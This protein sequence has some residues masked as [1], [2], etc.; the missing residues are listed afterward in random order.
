MKATV[1]MTTVKS[2]LEISG[3]LS[4]H[5]VG[6]GFPVRTLLS[7]Q[8]QGQGSS[9]FLLLDYA[10]PREFA[11]TGDRRGV[12]EHPH[13]GFETVTI[14]YQ[15]ELE[16]RDSAGHHGRLGPGDVQWMTAASG[17]VHEEMHE[18]EFARRGGVFEVVQL[19][20][21]LPAAQKLSPPRYQEIT[22]SRIPV[23]TLPGGAYARVIAGECG[24]IAGAARTVTPLNVWDVRVA[25]GRRADLK[26]PAGHNAMVALL[27]GEVTLDGQERL[28]GPQIVQLGRDGDR[29]V[30]EAQ[31][32]AGLLLLTGEPLD[33]P[34]VS[35]GPFVMNTEAEIRQAFDDYRSGRMGR[36]GG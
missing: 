25:A 3:P 16:H 1:P 24:G 5:W 10:G 35:A 15:G 17:I 4:T 7:P 36:L 29:V 14:V 12:E 18:R 31:S 28:T 6:N 19:W 21:N 26:I 8:V 32:D 22:D 33:E 34:I 9:P 13:R 2:V 20:V 30:I 23:V 27:R 11:P